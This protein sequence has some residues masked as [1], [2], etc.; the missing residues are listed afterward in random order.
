MINQRINNY[1]ILRKI[2]EGGM[3]NVYEGM[4]VT[5]KANQN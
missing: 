5:L 4:H 3:A 1:T 2:G